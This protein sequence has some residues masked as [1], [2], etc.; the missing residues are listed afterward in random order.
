M[1]DVFSDPRDYSKDRVHHVGFPEAIQKAAN[2]WVIARAAWPNGQIVFLAREGSF[3]AADL[4]NGILDQFLVLRAI[5]GG[6]EPYVPSQ[7]DISAIDWACITRQTF[8]R[9]MPTTVKH[10]A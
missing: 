9:Q 10:P 1:T 4:V 7:S 2:G 8:Q 3:V 6:Y 5:D